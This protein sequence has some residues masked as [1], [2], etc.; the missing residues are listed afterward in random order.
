M[1]R[2]AYS[3]LGVSVLF[4]APFFPARWRVVYAAS[5]HIDSFDAS[6]AIQADGRVTV[7]ERIAYDFS[8]L[9]RHG[10]YRDIAYVTANAEGK[11]FAMDFSDVTVKDLSGRPYPFVQS[12]VGDTLRWKIGD[13]DRTVT[14]KVSYVLD[15]T[16]SGAL[17]YFPGHDELYWNVSGNAWDVPIEKVTATVSLP[18]KVARDA[19]RLACFTGPSGSREKNCAIKLSDARTAAIETTKPL[20]SREGLT[21]VVGF[22]KGIV[23]VLEPK[24]MVPFFETRLGKILRIFIGIGAFFWYI[25]APLWVVW[26]WWTSGR[27]PKPAMGEATAWF[28]PPTTPHH[29]PLTPAETGTLVDE[30]ADNRDIYASIVDLARRGYIKIIETEKNVYALEKTK[31]WV[32]DRDVLPFERELLTGL[33]ASG[34]RISI[35]SINPNKTL[36]AVKSMLYDSLVADG[37]FPAN[38]NVVRGWYIALAIVSLGIFNPILF[39]TALIFGHHI[40]RKTLA[41]ADAAA[42]ARSLKNFL[43]RVDKKLAFQA[44]NQMLFEKVLPYAIAFGVERIWAERFKGLGLKHP[45]WYVSS[46]GGRFNSVVFTDSMSRGMSA[47]FASSIRAHSSTGHASGFSGGFSGGGGGGG[48]GGSW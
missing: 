1:K 30:R 6:F 40:P 47:S 5:E 20:G 38:P 17:R 29:R 32:G 48:G 13:A 23:A 46:S 31:D 26:K 33:F 42:V 34:E 37:F 45:T 7:A 41:G 39:L 25:V 21:I 12:T 24:E 18:V 19:Y 4:L 9:E 27:D 35:A 36:D 15:Y 8:D 10:I 11:R 3:L 14:G 44:K 22:P 43:I 16:V 28:S 2:A